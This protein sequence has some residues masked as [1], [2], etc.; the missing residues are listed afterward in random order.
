MDCRHEVSLQ[1]AV[2]V[3]DAIKLRFGI[4]WPQDDCIQTFREL[5]ELPE[6]SWRWPEHKIEIDCGHR[7]AL[8]GS[9]GVTNE[10]SF[11]FC[12]CQSVEDGVE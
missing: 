5:L 8:Q 10:N 7:R 3:H 4:V 1:A 2:I 12:L 11:E 6:T 9:S